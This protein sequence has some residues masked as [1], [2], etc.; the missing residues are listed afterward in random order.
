[1]PGTPAHDFIMS[2][3]MSSEHRVRRAPPA[4][5]AYRFRVDCAMSGRWETLIW[6]AS[7]RSQIPL[8]VYRTAL[9]LDILI[10]TCLSLV[11]GF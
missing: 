4:P 2:S 11:S 1:M 10:T 3:S 7:T 8:T 9:D 6:L 5:F